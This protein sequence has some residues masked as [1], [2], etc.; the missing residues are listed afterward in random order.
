MIKKPIIITVILSVIVVILC[1]VFLG[2]AL[3][4]LNFVDNGVDDPVD[5]HSEGTVIIQ[6]GDDIF[7]ENDPHYVPQGTEDPNATPYEDPEEK[8]NP[9][10]I[11]ESQLIKA[12]SVRFEKGTKNI[13]LLGEHKEECLIDSIFVLNINEEKHI[14]KLYSIPRDTYVPHGQATQEA[15]KKSRYYYSAGSFKLNAVYYIGRYIIKYQGGKFGNSGIDYT[16][17][18]VSQLL[19]GCEIDEYMLVDFDGFMDVIDV[20]GGVYVTVPENM[21]DNSGNLILAEGYQKLNAKQA[22][23]FCRYRIRNDSTGKNTGTGS[24]NFRKMNQANFLTEV[25]HQVLKSDMMSYGKIVDMMDTLKTSV[26]HSFTLADITDYLSVGM[27]FKNGMYT[28][29]PYVI[30]GDTIDP[31]N[32]NAYYVTLNG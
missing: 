4:V 26:Y 27:D 17:A 13:L 21:Y 5:E 10:V 16:A 9:G 31:F 28:L 25:F 6:H 8:Y 30:D 14:M 12:S 20:F 2:V 18:V 15:M 1:Q 3:P 22:L 23:D 19:P 7:N 32:D 11:N 24:D 29:Q